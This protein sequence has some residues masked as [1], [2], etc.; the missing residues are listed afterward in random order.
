MKKNIQD[1]Q[2][3]EYLKKLPRIEKIDET[4]SNSKEVL[5]FPYH[6][7]LRYEDDRIVTSGLGK[8]DDKK[9]DLL[10]AIQIED[11]LNLNFKKNN[12]LMPRTYA[13]SLKPIPQHISVQ[14]V[15]LSRVIEEG[16]DDVLRMIQNEH[17]GKTYYDKI[18]IENNE[19]SKKIQAGELLLVM[20]RR[21]GGWDGS[22]ERPVIEL[23][24]GGGHLATIWQQDGFQQMNPVDGIIKEFQEELGF[25]LSS[26]DVD[27]IGGFH[28]Q[29]SNELVIL[30]GVFISFN[31]IVDIQ[32]SARQNF[33]ECIDGLYLG[34]FRG[35]MRMYLEE[36]AS[37][38]AGGEK[39]KPSNFPSQHGLMQRMEKKLA[40]SE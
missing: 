13:E 5:L 7:Y 8:L 26:E 33:K 16:K 2:A 14:A 4:Y 24:G 32:H 23:L 22:Q 19:P 29:T 18:W 11:A 34:T 15:V 37:P 1:T 36:N 21:T 25:S 27:V 28:N 35:T 20:N 12:I 40:L 17:Y 3:S 38:F 31:K 10:T 6:A 9:S 30:C 39:T